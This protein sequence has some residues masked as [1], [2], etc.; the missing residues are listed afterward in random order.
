[1]NSLPGYPSGLLK[2][3]GLESLG[4]RTPFTIPSG[5]VTTVPSVIA[6]VARDVPG[7]GFL[8]T[9]TL[10]LAPRAGY[11]EPIIHEYYP[12][13][14]VNAV[15]LANPG[16][17]RFLETMRPLL[18]LH[19]RKPLLV[20]I[21]GSDPEEFLACAVVLEPIADAFELNLSCPHVKGAG[22]SVGSDPEAV[23]RVIRLLKD[24][25]R[26]PIIP[27]LS[28]NLGNIP[29]MAGLCEEAG[30]DGL[31]L[32]NTVGPGTATD[33]AGNPILTNVAGGLS[34]AGILPIGLKAVREAAEAVDLPIIASGGIGTSTDVRSYL[35][36]GASLFAVG[37]AL[38]GM[39]TREIR[40]F[41]DELVGGL[42]DD[43]RSADPPRCPT[44]PGRTAYAKT[45]VVENTRVGDDMF[46]LRLKEG[47]ACQ[48]GR[49]F[50]LRLVGEG[51][52]PF[53]P[54][55]D[56][57][58]VYLVRTVGPF[59]RAL[60]ELQPGM[61]IFLRGPYGNG[62]PDL[63]DGRPLILLGGGT[64]SAPILMAANRWKEQVSKCFVGFSKEV[65]DGFRDEIG[66]V[67][68]DSRIEIDP[69]DRPGAVVR[70]LA[71]DLTLNPDLYGQ[72]RVF[73]CGPTPMMAAAAEVLREAID[74]GRIFLAREDIMRC[75][76]GICGSCGT[77]TGLRS[78]IDGP[79]LPLQ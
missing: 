50:F 4:I 53:S 8:T 15:G 69:P 65:T 5:I 71:E 55:R 40:V 28:P 46:K 20:S 60:S 64:G 56:E 74:P 1:M 30:A 66:S 68:S 77:E 36:A 70:A 61:E 13:C 31:S 62:F 51:E 34:G 72:A 57:E 9:K 43:K 73:M 6:R 49:F 22:Q 24:R 48:P 63:D 67:F 19:D 23:R 25:I 14:F 52:K 76:I 17:E 44:S 21:M 12:G 3:S 2:G 45:S 42:I 18:P 27:K 32:I 54:A 41:F 35:Q 47:P 59:T 10:S 38:T 79:V 39:S 58:P 29:E 78:C 11:R 26:Q 16:A 7:I 33:L 75:G 37:S